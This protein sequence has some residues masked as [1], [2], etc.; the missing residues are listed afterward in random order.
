MDVVGHVGNVYTHL[1]K[2]VLQRTNGEG[3]IKVLGIA[4]VDGKGGYTT[5]VLTLSN[6]LGRN[7]CRNT[8]GSLL[9]LLGIDIRQA[10]LCQD[11]VHLRIVLA[12]LTQDILHHAEGVLGLFGPLHY[13]DHRLVA[14][15]P[16]LQ[17]LLGDKD[18]VGQGAILCDQ[19]GI[20]TGHLQRTHKGIVGA[21]Q[22]LHHFTFGHT[23]VA[24]GIVGNAY[25]V[26]CHGMGRVTLSNE[27]G[28]PPLVGQERILTVALALEDARHLHTA[29]IEF[30]A[31]LLHFAEIPILQQFVED[32]HSQ[33][34]QWM[35]IEPKLL[36]ELLERDNYPL[37]EVEKVEHGLNKLLLGHPLAGLLVFLFTHTNTFFWN[38]E[39]QRKR[40]FAR[41]VAYFDAFLHN[42][43]Q[44][45]LS[46]V[47]EAYLCS[48]IVR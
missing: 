9:D 28:L 36:K 41:Y 6:L 43:T 22:N 39:I 32:I 42:F 2:S 35:R 37:L 27:D 5:E 30:V 8:V 47:K 40:F 3:I 19:E 15:A 34:L 48:Q 10:K 23:S 21:L 26:A 7:L 20:S 16:T 13:L 14:V 25:A 24:L 46:F 1:P 31:M 44:L 17:V 33:H 45:A 11:G 12:R 29:V 4:R 38:F 18:V